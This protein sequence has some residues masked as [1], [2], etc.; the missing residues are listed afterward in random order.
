MSLDVKCNTCG[1]VLDEPGAV[2]ISPPSDHPMHP[3]TVTKYH[4][5]TVDWPLVLAAIQGRHD[6]V[7]YMLD[8][9]ET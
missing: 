6:D 9:R 2:A 5:C 1:E 7:R 8:K 3:D 4:I